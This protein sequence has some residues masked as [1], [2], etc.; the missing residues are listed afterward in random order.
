MNDAH[1]LCTIDAE[2]ADHL[3]GLFVVITTG[4]LFFL[5]NVL[6]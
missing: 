4:W 1:F 2:G 5:C 6:S 3:A